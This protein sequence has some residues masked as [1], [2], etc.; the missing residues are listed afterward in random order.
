M[1]LVVLKM[2]RLEDDGGEG[3]RKTKR[4]GEAMKVKAETVRNRENGRENGIES[5]GSNY[6]EI[7]KLW[8]IYV[9]HSYHI[10]PN[11]NI[12]RLCSFRPILFLFF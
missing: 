10:D 4:E 6:G 1:G 9:F 12:V 3:G 11:H 2:M 5:G 8:S 7:G